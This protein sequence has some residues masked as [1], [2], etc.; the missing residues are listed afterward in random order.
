MTL[1]DPGFMTLS[2]RLISLCRAFMSMSIN[3]TPKI[4]FNNIKRN[5]QTKQNKRGDAFRNS[6]MPITAFILLSKCLC[7]TQ[8]LFN[9]HKRIFYFQNGHLE[10]RETH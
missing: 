1:K 3:T 8:N 6:I 2:N 7:L 9:S 5:Q 10:Q 4:Q